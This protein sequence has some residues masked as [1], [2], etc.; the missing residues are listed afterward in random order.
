MQHGTISS[1]FT[2]MFLRVVDQNT[3]MLSK[4]FGPQGRRNSACFKAIAG[5]EVFLSLYLEFYF[6]RDDL[7][8]SE[9][10]RVREIFE[11]IYFVLIIKKIDTVS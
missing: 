6:A 4:A 10:S 5:S 3:A 8:V 11:D 9:R 7:S 2:T 1:K